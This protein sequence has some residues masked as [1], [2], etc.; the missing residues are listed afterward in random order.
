[1]GD[2]NSNDLKPHE[3]GAERGE[4][5]ESDSKVARENSGTKETRAKGYQDN[6]QSFGE[7]VPAVDPFGIDYGD[8]VETANGSKQK[9]SEPTDLFSQVLKSLNIFG[10]SDNTQVA[11]K[12]ELSDEER[13]SVK[14]YHAMLVEMRLILAKPDHVN[15]PIEYNAMVGSDF[16]K[17]VGASGIHRSRVDDDKSSNDACHGALYALSGKI[18]DFMIHSHP[19]LYE[20]GK[21]RPWWYFSPTD[22]TNIND[23]SHTYGHPITGFIL[24]PEGSV[25]QWKPGDKTTTEVHGTWGVPTVIGKFAANG[26]FVPYKYENGKRIADVQ[27][28]IKGSVIDSWNNNND[29]GTKPKERHTT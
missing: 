2:K 3:S 22:V 10:H 27:H 19:D 18:P 8:R 24:G 20:N 29:W 5:R 17:N 12:R 23:L 11:E 7:G 1:M 16:F 26:D 25:L 13:M 6:F 4:K 9:G 28:T 14:K 15:Q 21:E